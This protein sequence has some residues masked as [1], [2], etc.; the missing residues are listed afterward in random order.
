MA[1]LSAVAI[2]IR[3]SC[4]CRLLL[5]T[6]T[7]FAEDLN[8]RG[9]NTFL[10]NG[11]DE[12]LQNLPSNIAGQLGIPYPAVFNSQNANIGPTNFDP[13][14][15]Q[16]TGT[17][18]TG[19]NRSG[20]GGEAD[21]IAN[22][23][24]GSIG[25]F[26]FYD[27]DN[28]AGAEAV[29]LVSIMGNGNMGIGTT[30]PQ[31]LMDIMPTVP[32]RST[33]EYTTLGEA[34]GINDGVPSGNYTGA[35]SSITYTITTGAPNP[36]IEISSISASSGT[37]PSVVVQTL[38]NNGLQN[39]Q[40][41]RISGD[42]NY[43]GDYVV[44]NVTETT[45]SIAQSYVG[46]ASTSAT[47]VAA[48]T[49]TWNDGGPE[50]SPVSIT[51]G[52]SPL[53]NGVYFSFGNIVGHPEGCSWTFTVS[54]PA[55]FPNPLRITDYQGNPQLTVQNNGYVGIGTTAPNSKVH[56]EIGSTGTAAISQPADAY[57][58]FVP[59]VQGTG[60][61][62]GVLGIGESEN[63][64]TCAIG[65]YDDGDDG[66]QSLWFGTGDNV[67]GLSEKMRIL[68]GGYIGIGTTAPSTLVSLSETLTLQG[69]Q[70]ADQ[71]VAG[72]TLEPGYSSTKAATVP[73]HNYLT[74]NNPEV[75]SVAVTDAAVMCFN[76]VAG[77]HKA[78]D[79]GTTKVTPG[80]VN[81]WIKV[82]IAGTI[83]YMPAYTSKS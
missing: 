20:F 69:Y 34:G 80:T 23:G 56:V 45:F 19:W 29:Q 7:L 55:S 58:V 60:R 52:L 65:T 49:F 48:D 16:N 61:F 77:T 26:A 13:T 37:T 10:S 40:W 30:S 4:P 36:S 51:V 27:I 17:M 35:A 5:P 74:L 67:N 82:N 21:F 73:R 31:A 72:I 53:S 18:L 57:G 54:V 6:N 33:V 41:I 11:S 78:V 42:Q 28:T 39:N 12:S 63:Q 47:F 44:T 43:N 32:V 24:L 75:S 22:R 46:E 9:Q 3:P 71:F 70:P 83:Y 62:Q 25:G 2:S 1:I 79:S 66:S 14:I 50:S 8:V 38:S 81:A 68:S 59:A 15:L 76:A 64:I